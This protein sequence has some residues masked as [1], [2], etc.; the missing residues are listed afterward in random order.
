MPPKL[1]HSTQQ[2]VRLL[3]NGTPLYVCVH[4][5]IKL[6]TV[7]NYITLYDYTTVYNYRVRSLGSVST[8]SEQDS[9]LN[10]ILGIPVPNMQKRRLQRT[11]N[12]KY[13]YKE[14]RH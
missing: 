14:V 12:V 7:C 9:I 13:F 8:Q 4:I 11:V 5:Y 1:H 6:L 3:T 2:T 10:R